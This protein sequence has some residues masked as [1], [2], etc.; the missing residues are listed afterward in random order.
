MTVITFGGD[1]SWTSPRWAFA[2]LARATSLFVQDSRDLEVL[3]AAVARDALSFPSLDSQ[4]A[5]RLARE[6]RQGASWLR[7]ELL[8]HDFEDP[9]DETLADSLLPLALQLSRLL[10]EYAA[11]GPAGRT[12]TGS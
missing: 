10:N 1:E 8:S 6:L 11:S 2:R 3:D 9:L 7:E 12:T 4:R 5:C